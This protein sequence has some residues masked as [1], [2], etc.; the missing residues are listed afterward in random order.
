MEERMARPELED[1]E[2]SRVGVGQDR[3]PAPLRDDA[4]PS[5]RDLL[6]RDLPGDRREAPL[7]LGAHPPERRQ[8]PRRRVE[9][10]GVVVDLAAHHALGEGMPRVT[11]YS[12]DPPIVHGDGERTLGRTIVGTYGRKRLTHRGNRVA[13][14]RESPDR[15]KGPN[16][17]ANVDKDAGTGRVRQRFVRCTLSFLIRR[18]GGCHDHH[19]LAKA[20]GLLPGPPD[21]PGA[22]SCR[23]R[24]GWRRR[25]WRRRWWWRRARGA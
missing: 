21:R 1:P 13:Q 14:L 6:E 5:P 4:A 10:L 22:C 16:R 18:H 20:R 2:R 12:D 8:D 24:R 9:A 17:L 11:G 3:L 7:A 15:S 23:R 19:I 25:G